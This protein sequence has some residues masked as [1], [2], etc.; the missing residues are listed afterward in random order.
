[1]NEIFLYMRFECLLAAIIFILLIARINKWLGSRR[2]LVIIQSMLL[3]NFII[4][5]F[6]LPSGALFGNMFFTNDLLAFQKNLL[7]IALFLISLLFSGWFLSNRNTPE[8]F[9]LA[10]SSLLGMFLM[11]SSRNLMMF[12]V[13]I[14]LASI[15]LAALA[16]FDLHKRISSEAALKMIYSSA[17]ASGLIL[18]GISLLYG[19]TGSLRFEELSAFM[20]ARNGLFTIAFIFVLSSF[21]FKLSVVPF[22]FWTA[23][24]YQGA[25]I[26]VTA[27]LSVVSKGAMAFVFI[28]FLS[29]VFNR[30]SDSLYPILVALSMITMLTGNLFAIRQ[31]NMKRFLAFSSIAQMGFI[32]M[33]IS[34]FS[35]ASHTAVIYFIVVY[36]F[37]N[38][39]AF[40]VVDTIAANTGLENMNDYKGLFHNEPFLALMLAL[41][42]FSLAGIPPTAGFF[43]KLFLFSSSLSR[44]NFWLV[45]VAAVNMVIALFYYLKVVRIMFM[46][47]AERRLGDEYKGIRMHAAVRVALIICAIAVLLIG[48]IGNLYTFIENFA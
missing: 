14:E 40:A 28:T 12:Y 39:S 5:F 4:G 23:D 6:E 43:G 9:M 15:P 25:P 44:A 27:F 38:L 32:L 7:N 35:L 8:F 31:Q 17:I 11:M 22:H 33:A 21:A 29:Q 30:L 34:G 47:K 24:V 26:P 10:L 41:P 45:G 1:M 20:Q 13:A 3:V 46:E 19:I 16:N 2:M 36:M 48:F 42:L 18:F 37:S